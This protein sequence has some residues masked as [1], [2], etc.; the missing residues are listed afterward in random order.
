[1]SFAFKFHLV[2]CLHSSKP[3]VEVNI[4]K[5]AKSCWAS[6]WIAFLQNFRHHMSGIEFKTWGQSEHSKGCKVLLGFIL[7][8]F[9][10]KFQ[11]SHEWDRPINTATYQ[12]MQG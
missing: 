9:S 10:A 5:V 4:Q 11:A 6:F 7:N 3:G 2:I 1:M 8:C 12:T